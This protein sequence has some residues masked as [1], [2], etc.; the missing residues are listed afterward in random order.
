VTR[1][2]LAALLAARR[3]AGTIG[4]VV[5]A[6]GC[7]DLLH[8][9]HARYLQAAREHGDLLI[10]A[11]N[12]DAGVARLK[13]PG[14]PLVSFAERAELVAALRSVDFVIAF[15]EPTLA[16]TL[17]LLLPDVHAKG[18]DY[19]P[20]SVPEAALDREL[21]IAIA[22]CGDEKVRSTSGLIARLSG[23]PRR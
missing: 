12:D 10:V 1:E 8:V 4:R 3:R 22:I 20:E 14:R 21:G 17:R 6:N 16:E 11:L 7:F 5:L 23:L 2:E 19:T 9:G 13:G 18:S 15:G